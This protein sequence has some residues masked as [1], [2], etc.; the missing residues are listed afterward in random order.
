[1]N[2]DPSGRRDPTAIGCLRGDAYVAVKTC[3]SSYL[4]P[5]RFGLLWRL[6]RVY[7][8]DNNAGLV[9]H[10]TVWVDVKLRTVLWG[11]GRLLDG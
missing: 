7:V 5:P 6:R 8:S 2:F 1:M 3:S 10:V 4:E 11:R 9:D